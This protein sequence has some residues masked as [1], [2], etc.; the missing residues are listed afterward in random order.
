MKCIIKPGKPQDETRRFICLHCG[1]VFDAD[2]EDY[3]IHFSRN[4]HVATAICPCCKR[5]AHTSW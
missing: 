4:E 1:C 3:V 5:D 2:R